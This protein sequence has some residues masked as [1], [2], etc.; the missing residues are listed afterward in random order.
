[1]TPF[2]FT[3]HVDKFTALKCLDFARRF[4]VEVYFHRFALVKPS[5]NWAV[6]LSQVGGDVL[7]FCGNHNNHEL[8]NI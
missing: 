5:M 4:F 2:C 8:L 1:M 6:A 3:V 7:R